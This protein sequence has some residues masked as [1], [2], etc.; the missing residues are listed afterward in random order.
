MSTSN[1]AVRYS[2]CPC[3][4]RAQPDLSLQAPEDSTRKPLSRG[5]PPV[6]LDDGTFLVLVAELMGLKMAP[7]KKAHEEVCHVRINQRL[8]GPDTHS[9]VRWSLGW[10]WRW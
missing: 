1:T 2:R 3:Q 8:R 10:L 5:Y 6:E 4:H 7:E 9:V